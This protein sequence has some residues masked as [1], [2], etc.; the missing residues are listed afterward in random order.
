MTDPKI[1]L[2]DYDTGSEEINIERMRRMKALVRALY[3]DEIAP[4]RRLFRP[5]RAK[6]LIS[7]I[8]LAAI[9][10][11]AASSLY[12]FN[13]F[14]GLQEQV[15]SSRGHV[16]ANLQRRKNLF[17]NLVNITLTQAAVEKEIFRHVADVRSDL[18]S[19][20]A[21]LTELANNPD[22]AAFFNQ[23]PAAGKSSSSGSPSISSVASSLS[24]LLAIVE[25]YPDIKSS[26]T[27]QQLMDKLVEIENRISERRSEYN[28]NA[29]MFN[30]AVSAFPWYL[31]AR[32]TG[33]SRVEYFKADE[34]VG[35]VP[36]LTNKTFERLL[37]EAGRER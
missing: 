31:L 18:N 33:F 13:R 35:E 27:Y 8:S 34:N 9:I 14:I 28:D 23:A 6:G 32:A 24:R 21:L 2:E 30:H 16:E 11:M 12:N 26:T 37:P 5:I 29:R 20:N 17:A 19:T 36:V 25:Q 3:H 7:I 1:K 10:T 15:S 4:K 22:L